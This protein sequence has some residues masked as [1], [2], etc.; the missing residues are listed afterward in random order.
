MGRRGGCSRLCPLH[1]QPAAAQVQHQHLQICPVDKGGQG[2]ADQ[3]Q[4]ELLFKLF[5]PNPPS[6]ILC[7][8]SLG[9]CSAV[10]TRLLLDPG[11][12]EV[13]GQIVGTSVV[14]HH[15]KVPCFG[16][17]LVWCP[18]SN[19]FLHSWSYKCYTGLSILSDIVQR[20]PSI[21]K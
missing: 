10:F 17:S 7:I 8:I 15:T 12:T 14:L 9:S 4:F 16:F 11:L 5:C 20:Y 19:L 21:S 18:E 2:C 6:H 3:P 1:S 13:L